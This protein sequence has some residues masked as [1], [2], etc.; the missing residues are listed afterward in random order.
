M[1]PI[2]G[3]STDILNTWAS[4]VS[5]ENRDEMVTNH[6][7]IMLWAQMIDNAYSTAIPQAIQVASS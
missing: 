2:V 7:A 6:D 3:E 1:T 4:V 5:E